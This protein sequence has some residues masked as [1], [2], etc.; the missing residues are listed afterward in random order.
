MDRPK[1]KLVDLE[2]FIA[3]KQDFA[4]RS[5]QEDWDKGRWQKELAGLREKYADSI[6]PEDEHLFDTYD[7]LEQFLMGHGAQ[8]SADFQKEAQHAEASEERGVP[9]VFG[10][11]GVLTEQGQV[12]FKPFLRT[13]GYM[14]LGDIMAITSAPDRHS[15]E[16]LR[17]MTLLAMETGAEKLESIIEMLI[18]EPVGKAVSD[19]LLKYS[20]IA[21]VA[22][23]TPSIR[24][25]RF[26]SLRNMAA[27]ATV[28][29]CAAIYAATKQQFPELERWFSDNYPSFSSHVPIAVYN[30]AFHIATAMAASFIGKKLIKREEYPL[31]QVKE[32]LIYQGIWGPFRH[33]V[34]HYVLPF[35]KEN[36]GGEKVKQAAYFC[37]FWLYSFGYLYFTNKD[38]EKT[39]ADLRAEF[40]DSMFD[41]AA[42]YVLHAANVGFNPLEVT[43]AMVGSVLTMG[44]TISNTLISYGHGN[45]RTHLSGSINLEKTSPLEF[46]R[47]THKESGQL[48]SQHRKFAH[49][50]HG[51]RAPLSDFYRQNAP[52]TNGTELKL[53]ALSLY[54]TGKPIDQLKRIQSA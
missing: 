53:D 25:K 43:T 30:T 45:L 11:M 27:L 28:A 50:E 7:D 47:V 2:A 8:V 17:L 6:Y 9:Y 20:E 19:E 12:G 26:A 44:Y 52:T 35:I 36:L 23:P 32:N 31:K 38:K 51:R 48:R 15:G 54:L 14:T 10:C 41:N 33:G 4:I 18:K 1:T 46:L 22:S 39:F 21:S 24:L 13:R 49:F 3:E 5:R 16:D 34:Y 29:A 40:K 42:I 37:H